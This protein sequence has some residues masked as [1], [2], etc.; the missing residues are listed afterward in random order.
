MSNDDPA[1]NEVGAYD[2]A[3][4]DAGMRA[5][6][7][8]DFATALELLLPCAEAGSV[9]AQMLMSR[10]YYAGN[11]VPQD[12]ERYAYWLERAAAAGEKSARAKLKRLR[13]RT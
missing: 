3:R 7:R 5:F 11:G 1:V 9:R 13:T 6:S 2:E 12:M 10:L 8:N 4:L